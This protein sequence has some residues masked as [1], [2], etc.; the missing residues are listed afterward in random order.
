MNR[1]V[2]PFF[3]SAVLSGVLCGATR[4]KAASWWRTVDGSACNPS[5]ADSTTH[6]WKRQDCPFVS[7]TISGATSISGNAASTIYADYV[8]GEAHVENVYI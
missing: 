8:V 7:D 3:A 5:D 6:Y 1:Y 2:V 4:A